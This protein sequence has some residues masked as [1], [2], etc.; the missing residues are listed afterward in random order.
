MAEQAHNTYMTYLMN[1][2]DGT[3]WSKLVDI[4]EFPDLGSAPPTLDTT[5]LSDAMHTYINDILD[6]GGGLE[7]TCN[8]KLEDYKKLSGHVGK[9]EHYAL[10]FG[11]TVTGNVV[12]PSGDFGKFAFTGQL[13]VWKKG[14]GVG[15]VQ[16]MG[17]SIAPSSEVK[18]DEGTQAGD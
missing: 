16:D 5:T 15:A 17:V 11:G 3:T 8:Y 13:S 2:T 12:T 14:G 18:L 7:F 9:D 4:K 6:T 1:S 10:W